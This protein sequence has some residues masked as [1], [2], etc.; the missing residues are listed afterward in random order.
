MFKPHVRVVEDNGVLVADFW[1][2]TRLDQEPV[3]DLRSKVNERVNAGGNAD[4][5]VDFQGVSFAGSASLS[6]FV[7]LQR[8]C[9]RAGGQLVLCGLD[10]TVRDSFRI[11]GLE[12]LFHFVSSQEDALVAI[13]NGVAK[14]VPSRGNSEDSGTRGTPPPLRRRKPGD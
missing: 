7:T 14:G 10:A 11:S 9:R 4:L 2:C 3:R 13:R 1:D 12:T 8:D 6:G 5:V